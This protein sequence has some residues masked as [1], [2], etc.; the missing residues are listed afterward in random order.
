MTSP[1]E[2][3]KAVLSN[4]QGHVL[5]LLEEDMW[6]LP[7]GGL[8]SG[9]SL[10]HGVLREIREETGL[11]DVV[12]DALVLIEGFIDTHG[13][14]TRAWY[15]ACLTKSDE[16]VLSDEHS[17]YRWVDPDALPTNLWRDAREA[18]A[19]SVTQERERT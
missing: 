2:A 1:R 10:H 7:G 6:Q 18:I 15:Y 4:A 9:E 5:L 19:R 17:A 3:V 8:D 12:I 13:R 16:I 11:E 14:H